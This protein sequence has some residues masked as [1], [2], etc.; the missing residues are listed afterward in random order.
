MAEGRV[1]GPSG[2]DRTALLADLRAESEQLD[3]LVAGVADWRTATPAPG[4]TIAHQIGHLAW[5]DAKAHLAATDAAGFQDEVER[6][7]ADI[8]GYV[9]G[10]AERAAAQNPAELLAQWRR[11]REA[12][13]AALADAPEG[14]RIPWYGPPMGVAS[15]I[16]ARLME[17]WAHGQ[18]VLDA[19]GRSREPTRRLRHIARLGVRTRDFAHTAHGMAPPEEQFH[20][21]LTGPDG[22]VWDFGPKHAQDRVAGPALDFCLVVT[23]RRHPDDTELVVS[24]AGARQWIG[25]AQA[26]AGPP[27]Q[28]RKAGEFA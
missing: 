6:A 21:E 1:A 14:A 7:L 3:E 5:T 19:L 24:G 4:W 27:G 28:G 20:V 12:L 26:F 16:T 8:D 9:D 17:T 10:G 15:M 13:A 11:G 23:Q 18:D 22:E 2:V 25:I